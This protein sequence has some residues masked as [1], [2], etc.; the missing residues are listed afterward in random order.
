MKTK[1]IVILVVLSLCSQFAF[2]Q[3]MQVQAAEQDSLQYNLPAPVVESEA[4]KEEWYDRI[5]IR[6]YG[7]V[8]YNGLQTNPDLECDQCDDSWGGEEEIFLR[9][10][11]IIFFGNVHE[12]LYFYVQPDFASAPVSGNLHFAQIRD[13]YFDLALDKN[14]EFRLRIG[15]SKIPYGYENM[16]SSQNRL[17]LDRNDALNSAV[18]NERDLGGFFYWTPRVVQERFAYMSGNNL[19]GTGNYGMLGI[20]L[21]NGQTANRRDENNNFHVVTRL[22]YPFQFDNGQI[23]EAGIQAYT[24]KYVL[25]RVTPEVKVQNENLEYLDQRLAGTLAIYPQ[26]FGLQAEYTVGTG[27]EYNSSTNTIEQQSL[28]GGY[29]LANYMIR[30]KG[31]FIIPFTRYQY[32]DGGK[33][34]ELDARSYQVSELEIGVEWQPFRNFESVFMYTISDRTFEDAFRPDNRQQGSLLRVQ[35]QFNI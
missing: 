7:Q 13:A 19:K 25:Y 26:P 30:H 1:R 31:Q 28:H 20:G 12:R 32:Y 33:K 18:R 3:D 24:G 22:T 2:S 27:P 16:Q 4:K 11:R 17:P 23:I 8:R 35:L 29:V 10:M 15:Q 6:G 21:Y 34:H 5:N 14:Q 9:R